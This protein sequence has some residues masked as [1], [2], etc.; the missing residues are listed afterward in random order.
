MPGGSPLPGAELPVINAETFERTCAFL[1]SDVI[2][3]YLQAIAERS[4]AL[5]QELRAMDLSLAL[6]GIAD[7]AHALAGSTG[8]FGFE[9]LSVMGRRFER[10]IQIGT[11]DVPIL[12]IGLS[13][14]LEGALLEVRGRIP[15]AAAA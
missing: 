11:P 2:T 7:A 6:E 13:A 12:A 8:M 14:A 1:P 15:V 5:L 10:A 4:E 3:S 9:R